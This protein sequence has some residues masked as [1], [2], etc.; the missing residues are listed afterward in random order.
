[1]QLTALLCA[2]AMLSVAPGIEEVKQRFDQAAQNSQE[3]KALFDLLS[4]MNLQPNQRMYAWWGATETLLA[5][6]ALMPT[7]KLQLLDKGMRKLNACIQNFPNDPEIILLR[8]TIQS[9]LPAFLGRSDDLEADKEFL[10]KKIEQ[11]YKAG[12][13]AFV[14]YMCPRMKYTKAL[15]KQKE[16]LLSNWIAHCNKK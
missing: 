5:K 10:M 11:K 16:A 9:Q 14:R 8:F 7:T 15:N 1:M 2:F 4:N 13:C 3:A 6:E 12:D